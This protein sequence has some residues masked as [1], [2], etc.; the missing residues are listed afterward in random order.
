MKL[1]VSILLTVTFLG[2]ISAAEIIQ[3]TQIT[4]KAKV[5]SAT[6]IASEVLPGLTTETKRQ[7]I[8]AIFLE[9]EDKSRTVSFENDYTQLETGDL[10]FL[11]KT[12]S[13]HDGSI[14]YAMSEPDRLQTIYFF[15]ALFVLLV[16][17]FGGRQGIRGLVS[18][19]GSL[20]LI[21]Y[22][23][24]PSILHGYSPILVSVGV[25]SLII[26]LGSYV[27]HGF[28]KTTTAAVFGMI[29]TVICSGILAY[30]ATH[31]ARLSGFANE[32]AVYLNFNTRGTIDFVGLL[33]GGMLIGLLG[34]LYD[35]AI[36]QAIAVEELYRAGISSKK[37]VYARAL[38]IGKEHIGALVNTLAIA[39]VGVSLPLLL[40]FSMS[41]SPVLHIINR[42]VFATELIRTMVGSIG[43][44]LAVP[45]TTLI[46]T[47]MLMGSKYDKTS[48][49]S[50]GHSH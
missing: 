50:H 30:Y 21:L 27:T 11:T 18:L 6:E 38:R 47:L 28:N 31:S 12:T 44:V 16:I 13:G 25:A 46:A 22:V 5:I 26:I 8:T 48:N 20:L 7:K 4:S 39:Y 10:F 17:I 1:L 24:I 40:L 41:D 19:I 45:L 42:E 35:A 23:P 15:T 43:L 37:E 49:H 9:G 36:G 14:M 34:V 32:E 33:L 29:A 3:D 2:N